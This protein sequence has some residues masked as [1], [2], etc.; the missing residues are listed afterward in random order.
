MPAQLSLQ[1]D[2]PGGDAA[3]WWS[4]PEPA[5]VEVLG[6]LARLIARDVLAADDAEEGAW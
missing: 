1:V 5:R 4:L 2:P 3:C 6:L